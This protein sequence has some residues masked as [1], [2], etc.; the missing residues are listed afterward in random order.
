MALL[1]G[2]MFGLFFVC[3]H[4]TGS[5]SG[6]YPLLAARLASVPLIA[7]LALSRGEPLRDLV[8]GRGIA[9]ALAS[10][11]LDMAA[12]VLYLVALR[13]GLLAV[14]SATTG[15]YPAAT[16]ILAQRVLDERMR[17]T[18]VAG[19]AVAGL[20]AALVAV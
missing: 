11:V 5:D 20:A 8:G 17:R 6:M 9:V 18:Q 10:G 15:L 16:V 19:L 1:A 14:V 2:T 4:G 7:A 3:L 13:H 12:N